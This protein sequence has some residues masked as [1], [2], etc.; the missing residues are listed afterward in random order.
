MSGIVVGI[1]ESD[2]AAN[3]LRWAVR[4]AALHDWNVTAVMAWGL[5]DQ[6]TGQPFN[7]GYEEADAARVL[8]TLVTNAVGAEPAATIDCRPVLDLP[9]RALVDASTDADLLVVGARG[10]GGFTGLL[11]GSVSQ[12]CLH[13]ANVPVAIVRGTPDAPQRI[14]VGVD[15]SNSAARAARWSVE[16]A[17]L[18]GA[19]VCFVNGWYPYGLGAFPFIETAAPSSALE[20]ASERILDDA[21]AE[22]EIGDVA[23]ERASKPG[24]PASVLLEMSR[25]DDLIVLGS[26][27]TSRLERFFVGSVTTQVAQHVTTTVVVVPPEN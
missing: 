25:P 13:Q 8:Q 27:S 12:R 2:H 20:A 26:R 9:G 24:N 15:G 16:E 4:E 19:S 23:V 22:A 6:H 1:D 10:S 17:S 18:S 7:P 3:A 21:L 14:L 11:L 5:L